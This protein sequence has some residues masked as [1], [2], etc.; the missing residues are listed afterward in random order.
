MI[1]TKITD[2]FTCFRI[3]KLT[4]SSF[5]GFAVSKDQNRLWFVKRNAYNQVGWIP[6]FA[7]FSLLH[8]LLMYH[9]FNISTQY[10]HSQRWIFTATK[11]AM[12]VHNISPMH[13]KTTQWV[14]IATYVSHFYHHH[15]TIDTHRSE[16]CEQPNWWGR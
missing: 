7:I 1:N 16:C 5:N 4:R 11:S 12:Q 8:S 13:Y 6:S 15:S 14:T 10:S 9:I 2:S 3:L